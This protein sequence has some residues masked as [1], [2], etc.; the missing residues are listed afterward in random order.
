MK[1]LLSI[2]ALLLS[3][4]AFSAE[5]ELKIDGLIELSKEEVVN[6]RDALVI[7]NNGNRKIGIC[8]LDALVR[9]SDMRIFYD[10]KNVKPL[11]IAFTKA[12]W[13]KIYSDETMTQI[14]SAKVG[15]WATKK[16][17]IG[18]LIKPIFKDIKVITTEQNC[19]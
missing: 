12:E 17:N 5:E 15:T 2:L 6:V 10:T 19:F 14:V 11:I 1:I 16:I 3:F 7:A 4:N 8:E 18:T 13:L 9:N